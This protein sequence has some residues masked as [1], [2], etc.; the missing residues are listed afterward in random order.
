MMKVTVIVFNV[1]LFNRYTVIG[2]ICEVLSYILKGEQGWL[3][4]GGGRL[5]RDSMCG[6]A[7]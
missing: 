3:G 7:W 1:L 4:E 6:A 2:H 5:S